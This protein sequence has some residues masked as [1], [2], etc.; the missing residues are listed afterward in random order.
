M[1]DFAAL[2]P[3]PESIVIAGENLDLSP[4]RIGELSTFTRAI[5]PFAKQLA[6]EVDWTSLIA[7]HGEA[8]LQ[9]LAIAARRP[10]SWVEGL[11]VDEAIRLADA[12]LEV[13]ADFFV[14][15][16]TPACIRM[17]G[18]LA[19]RMAGFGLSSGSSEPATATP[20]S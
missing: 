3:V 12:L 18:N 8:V 17:A 5:R 2:P 7:D 20:T 19:S 14:R 6:G 13:N 10:C 4:L 15:V 1:D 9:A 11:A 16:V